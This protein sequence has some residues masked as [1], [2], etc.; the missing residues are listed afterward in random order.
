M[1]HAVAIILALIAGPAGSEPAAA[2]SYPNRPLT[3]IHGFA[4]GGNADTMARILADA[5]DD[6]LGQRV[7]VDAR[8]GAGGTLASELVTRAAADGHTLLMLTAGHATTAHL[9]TGLKYDPVDDFAMVTSIA[10]YPYVVAVS[11]EHPFRSLTDMIRTAKEQPEAVTYTS[12]GIGTV[13]H[14]TGELIASQAGVKM[15][16]IPYRGGIAPMTDV[17][18]GRVDVLIDTQTVSMPHIASG[19]ARGLGVTSKTRWPGTPGVPTVA[20]TLPG[21]HVETWIG[22]ATVKG[23][24]AAIVERLHREAIRALGSPEVA[25]KLRGLGADVRPSSPG[26]MRQLVRSEVDRWG[27]VIRGA[28]ILPQ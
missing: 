7:M 3:L 5:L 14:L 11:A 6:T 28:G 16:H 18:A 15:T 1:I 26:A 12:V 13:P 20:E 25:A 4:P 10:F 21:F 24:P 17:L 2:Q 9:L 23:T 27:V 8:P 22:L 19:A